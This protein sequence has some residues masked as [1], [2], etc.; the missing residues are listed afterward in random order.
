MNSDAALALPVRRLVLWRHGR[1]EWN[2]AQRF[3]GHTDVALDDTGREQAARAAR[4]L[5]ALQPAA[6]VAS[7]LRRAADTAGELARVTGLPVQA[8]PRLRETYA[9]EWQGLTGDE[10]RARYA[11]SW[12]VWAAGDVHV[13]PGGGETRLEVAERVV[14]AVR[15]ALDRTTEPGPLVVATHGGAARVA[16]GA[17]LGLP[18]ACWAVVGGLSNCCWSVLAERD[19]AWQ[20]VEHNAGTLP[21]PLLTEEG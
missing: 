21:Q 9:G 12:R 15:E 4:L 3:Q 19:G 6:V 13:R 16:I 8:D 10:I 17:L 14:A 7:D 11:D 5:A 18:P 1:T 20:L 2:A